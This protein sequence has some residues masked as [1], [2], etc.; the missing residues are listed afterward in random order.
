MKSQ[1]N[2]GLFLILSL[3]LTACGGGGSGGGTTPQQPT[4]SAPVVANPI[5]DMMANVG[6]SFSFTIPAN[7]C[8]DADNDPITIST[9]IDP[10]ILGLSV[11]NNVVSGILTAQGSVGVDVTC[12]ATGG[13]VVDTFSITS[14]IAGN[15]VPVIHSSVLTDQ[16]GT[17]N[18]PFSYTVP[19][20]FCTDVDG[21][22]LTTRS[23]IASSDNQGLTANGLTISGTP[24]RSGNLIINIFCS[25][26]VNTEIGSSYNINIQTSGGQS[27]QAPIIQIDPN[28][29][30]SVDEDNSVTF[31]LTGLDLDGSIASIEAVSQPVN[32]TLTGL[33]ISGA[34]A[35][36][37][38]TPNANFSGNDSFQFTVTD[39]DGISSVPFTYNIIV[40]PT[41]DPTVFT[42]ANTAT[43]PENN[44]AT[45]YTAVATDIDGDT[46]TY[47]LDFNAIVDSLLFSINSATGELSFNTAVDFEN[48]SDAN[49]DNVY[50]AIISINSFGATGSELFNQTVSVTVTDVNEIPQIDAGI[51]QSVNENTL[52]T[53][54][55]LGSDM[56]GIVTFQWTQ[57]SGASVS[58]NNANSMTT[59]F[60]APNV[61]TATTLSF[62][63]TVT[64]SG[65]VSVT[66]TVLITVQ[67]VAV[68][69]NR[70]VLGPLNGATVEAF[71][72]ADINYNTPLITVTTSNSQSASEQGGW[73]DLVITDNS[74]ADSDWLV[75]RV[76][77]GQDVDAD[78]DGVMDSNPT[79]NN[80]SFFALARK[81][82]IDAGDVVV[83]PLTD[84]IYLE[85]LDSN[86]NDLSTLLSSDIQTQLDN[87]SS[88]YVNDVN[89]DSQVN[90][91]DI[92]AFEPP[93]HRQLS[94]R[95]WSTVLTGYVSSIHQGLSANTRRQLD[96]S[97][98][99]MATIENAL[100]TGESATVDVASSASMI[101][102]NTVTTTV[103]KIRVT[104]D[105]TATADV[106]VVQLV[107]AQTDAI[108]QLNVAMEGSTMTANAGIV[109]ED[110]TL[111]LE[112]VPESTPLFTGDAQSIANNMTSTMTV[113]QEGNTYTLTISKEV[114]ASWSA[115]NPDISISGNTVAITVIE[116]DPVIGWAFCYEENVEDCSNAPEMPTPVQPPIGLPIT[117]CREVHLSYFLCENN[118]VVVLF[119]PSNRLDNFQNDF[120]TVLQAA[121]SQTSESV[122][123]EL[124]NSYSLKNSQSVIDLRLSSEIQSFIS[125]RSFWRNQN[126]LFIALPENQVTS[127]FDNTEQAKIF[128]D[129]SNYLVSAIDP[130]QITGLF[131]GSGL[132]FSQINY[133]GITLLSGTSR[134]CST[135]EECAENPFRVASY[136][137]IALMIYKTPFI[138][139]TDNEIGSVN[140]SIRGVA[141]I[142]DTLTLPYS[143]LSLSELTI[144][145]P[146]A[147]ISLIANADNEQVT[148]TWD[149]VTGATS[150]N[151]YWSN[152]A[153]CPTQG[154]DGNQISGVTP[155]Y[156]HTGLTNGLNYCYGVTAVNSAGESLPSNT[157]GTTPTA[158][159]ENVQ[160]TKISS[161][162]SDLPD[163]ATEWSCV[164]DNETGLIWE[165]KT[166]DGGIHDK[167]NTYRWGGIG[168]EGTSGISYGDWDSLVTGS[169]NENLCGYSDWRVPVIEELRGL[170][171]CSSGMGGGT[172]PC[173]DV[174]DAS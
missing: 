110:G 158:G 126:Q 111:N 136:G 15:T 18:V 124:I 100:N 108:V 84:I 85:L 134:G 123:N 46:I 26:A 20:N 130:S 37:S 34:L 48:P 72:L 54:S 25:D 1:F 113:T 118:E 2:I 145:I 104:D 167:D 83:N 99:N 173:T 163:S 93:Q 164:R 16:T 90:Y 80:G 8:T 139:N 166:D 5:V 156:T 151:L 120:T 55:G 75:I 150:Y 60:T 53:L 30:I 109:T 170:V 92:L 27:N 91:I 79:M 51:D 117:D 103:S 154:T 45:F 122:F 105:S 29:V 63:L 36:V 66:D 42:S 65:N 128:K 7:V 38:Y 12:S 86:N 59:T 24:V 132:I 135:S 11:A 98:V 153:G 137:R 155:P 32:G 133:S 81:S 77:R 43:V 160:Y 174:M 70:A 61:N 78:D 76:S 40:N 71:T 141:G 13:S 47:G 17:I 73:F 23:E 172:T 138:L 165:I 57:L 19:D 95:N 67:P 101:T 102:G 127:N 129:A 142:D 97:L 96:R 149:T 112:F 35:N 64:D 74:I 10:N 152:T 171:Y 6:D 62:Q 69:A 146:T 21:D 58:L 4:N 114:M 41:N 39:N 14:N 116:D 3:V 162:G 88:N 159:I 49:G 144:P 121:F 115:T 31:T 107:S 169:R 131:Y 157:F 68:G 94:I 28:E 9:S 147:P 50:L 168:T 125:M 119:I 161:S 56:E 33:P 87:L 44:T 82:E 22:T 52:V 140:L 106:E 89:N 148:L 143:S